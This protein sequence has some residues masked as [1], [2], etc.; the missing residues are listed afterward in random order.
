VAVLPDLFARRQAVH[1][2]EVKVIPL[3]VPEADRAIS[4]MLPE[5]ATTDESTDLLM[6]SLKLAAT[7]F[8]L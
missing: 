1:R 2:E 4:L 7:Q 8:G 6:K 5:R 3:A